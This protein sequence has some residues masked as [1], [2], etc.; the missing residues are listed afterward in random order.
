MSGGHFEYAGRTA[1]GLLEAVFEDPDVAR[2]FPAIRELLYAVANW[3]YTVEHGIDWDFSG[4]TL[5]EDDAAWERDRLC[6]LLRHAMHA[7][8]DDLF[9][10]GKWATIQAIEGRIG[11]PIADDAG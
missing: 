7:A 9:P 5:I 1:R 3:V 6:E 4:D 2:R 11:G 10:R 8:P